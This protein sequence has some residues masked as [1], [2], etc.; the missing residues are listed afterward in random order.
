MMNKLKIAAILAG[1]VALAAPAFGSSIGAVESSY[2]GSN[3]FG[4]TIGNTGGGD[5]TAVVTA[6]LSQ[7]G[8]V[9]GKTYTSYASLVNDGTGSVDVYGT[10]TQYSGYTPT[11][12]DG[13]EVSSAEYSPYH[14]LPE[15]EA[16]SSS[17]TMTITQNSTGN[18]VPGNLTATVSQM[19]VTT[20]PYNLAGYLIDLNNAYITSGTGTGAS[21]LTP[22]ETFGTGNLQLTVT[23]S[24]GSEELY[25][26]PT[27]Y[28]LANLDLYGITIP[29]GVPVDMVGIASV[30]PTPAPGAPEF[31][32]FSI[33][34]VPEPVSTGLLA[35]GSVA[36]LM[37]RRRTA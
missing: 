14:Q 35:V 25:Y 20:L 5:P 2:S 4:Q 11:V 7:P 1:S 28:S 29:V 36:L 22:G 12:G 9:H 31:I 8:T 34:V 33:T 18:P 26:Y 27:S 13:I 16:S 19:N 32:P 10:A 24:T 17:T 37:R 3:L 21:I 23:D 30:Y 6:I 15:L